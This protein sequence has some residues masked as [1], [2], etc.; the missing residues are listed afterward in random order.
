MTPSVILTL[1]SMA[2]L[3]LS[4]WF[5]HYSTR[6]LK[7]A[8]ELYEDAKAVFEAADTIRKFTPPVR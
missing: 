1:I 5:D 4:A 3:G 6:R 2:A 8:R 7:E